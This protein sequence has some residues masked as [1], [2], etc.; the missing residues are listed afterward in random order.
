[1]NMN[2]HR[3]NTTSYI[4][5]VQHPF[6]THVAKPKNEKWSLSNYRIRTRGVGFVAWPEKKILDVDNKLDKFNKK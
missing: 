5:L 1:M 6:L 4:Y 2:K 3:I